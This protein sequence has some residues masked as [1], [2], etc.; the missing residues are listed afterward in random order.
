MSFPVF[1]LLNYDLKIGPPRN[2][3]HERESK[4]PT[5]QGHFLLGFLSLA[6][7]RLEVMYILKFDAKLPQ[8][9]PL[10]ILLE[11]QHPSFPLSP[12]VPLI[13]PRAST[14]LSRFHLKHYQ[15]TIT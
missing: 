10:P 1:Y 13:L 7:F 9:V 6:V 8:F 4:H 12:L 5:S 11:L 3:G 15:T 2:T 14:F